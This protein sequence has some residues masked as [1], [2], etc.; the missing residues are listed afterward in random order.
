MRVPFY[1]LRILDLDLREE[2]LD[3]TARV[4]DHGQ[5]I[6]G[7][8]VESFEDTVAKEVGVRHAIGVGSGSSA[9]YLALKAAG[10]QAGDEVITTPL[11]WI[12]T[13][14]AIAATGATPV[15]ADVLDDYN[16]NPTSV[17]ACITPKT[18][19][20]VPMHFAG[21]LC[22]MKALEK[23]ANKH[24]VP[25]IEDAAQAFGGTLSGKAAGSFSLVSAFSMNPMKVLGA[26]GEA[27]VV[28]TNDAMIAR[29]IRQL[30]HAGT[31]QDPKKIAI[32][33][34]FSVELNQKL[35]ALQAALLK[36]NLK[37][38]PKRQKRR[39]EIA[40]VL[41]KGLHGLAEPQ[42]TSPEE[43][44]A[45]YMFPVNINRREAIRK[46]LH[47]HNVETKICYLPLASEAPIY[48][49]NNSPTFPNA[50]RL[51][52]SNLVIPS[53]EKL[54]DSQVDFLVKL[55]QNFHNN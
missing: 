15:F 1:D 46:H 47:Y 25:L 45:R 11:T 41:T 3:A 28:V 18:R 4:L 42:A 53:H 26:Y 29:K 12:I 30:R 24:G 9:L 5:L 44:H 49:K 16:I 6:D 2:L 34:C 38:L 48:K 35:D 21:H 19:A 36:V 32:N 22:E 33:N 40:S 23:I 17:E 14:N 52:R 8:E 39:E 10:I 7:P 50:G 54:T 55:I 43:K 31:R 37:H 51:V 20:I 27:G 13:V